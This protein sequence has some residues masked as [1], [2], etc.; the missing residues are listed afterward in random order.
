MY[1]LKNAF[2]ECN[3]GWKGLDCIKC[4]YGSFGRNCS[5]FCEGCISTMCDNVNGLCDNKSSCK[6]GYAIG[7][8]CNTTCSSDT[9]GKDCL[10]AC[11]TNC[12][13]PTCNH[14]NGE[15]I[16]ECNDGW[17]GLDCTIKCPNG[18]F[19]RNCL[20]FCDGCI[21]TLCDNVNGLCDNKTSCKPGYE[22]GEY[23]NTSCDD[24]YFGNNCTKQCHCLEKPC[25]NEDRICSLEGCKKGWHGQSCDQGI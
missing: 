24:W 21:S 6:P 14:I 12:L 10:Q 25:N 13:N 1:H 23:C 4:P 11:S 16:G 5:G 18:S 9:Y 15:C 8:Y 17:K 22:I 7:E 2:G 19:G 20:G 3:D